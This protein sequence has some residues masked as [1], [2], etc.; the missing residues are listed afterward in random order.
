MPQQTI[1][2]LAPY[3]NETLQSVTR[4]VN[5]MTKKKQKFLRTTAD[6]DKKAINKTTT[7][8]GQDKSQLY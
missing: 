6:T 2:T 8:Q 5:H 3:N 4:A 1:P 7:K